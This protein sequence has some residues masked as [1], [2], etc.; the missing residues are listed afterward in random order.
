MRILVTGGAGFIGSHIVDALVEE[1]HQVSVIDNLLGTGENFVNPKVNFYD[2]NITDEKS[3]SDVF[4]RERPQVVNHHAAQTNVRYSMTETAYDAQ[5]NVIGSINVLE[6][7]VKVGVTKFVFAS[8]C[9]VYAEPEQIP[10]TEKHPIQPKSG[11]GLSKY[12]VENY[13]KFYSETYGLPYT[14]FRYGNV[15]GPRQ[16]PKGEAG[17]IAIFAEQFLTGVRP[18]IFGD[19]TKTRDY[20]YV[21]DIVKANLFAMK[22]IGDNEMFNLASGDE[23]TDFEVFEFVRKASDSTVTPFF[24]PRRP[25]EAD[26]VALDCSKAATLLGWSP[27][28][29]MSDGVNNTVTHYIKRYPKDT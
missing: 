16:N 26:R 5:V 21:A 2:V 7:C 18:T 25:G 24:S 29:S 8:T 3:I 15:Y 22:S 14:V 23:T 17:V 10:M 19:G 12:T 20:I 6:S 28:V 9:A 1:G 13:V 11:Y 27:D 4:E